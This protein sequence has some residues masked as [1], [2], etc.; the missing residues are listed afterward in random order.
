MPAAQRRRRVR[1][2]QLGTI[3]GVGASLVALGGC[4]GSSSQS[5]S[6]SASASSAAASAQHAQHARATLA[7]SNADVGQASA[8]TT[9]AAPPARGSKAKLA[10]AR[11]SVQRAGGTQKARPTPSSSN[12]DLSDTGAR[13]QNPC[14]LVSV[15]E[16]QAITGGRIKGR[17]EAPLG[18]TCIYKAA[19][20]NTEITVAVESMSF[21]QV[22]RQ[23]SRRERVTV[24]GHQA[25]CG[26]LGTQMLVVALQHG[27]LLHVTGSC[28][29]ARQFAAAALARLV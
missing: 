25:Y 5:S 3:V 29:V 28:G 11:G 26:H 9:D 22:T 17:I 23:L 12:D 4:G 2:A 24:A 7:Q 27:Q 13:P 1:L 18:P 8:Q 6:S 21:S 19:K 20:P 16:A 15:A 10:R 14:T